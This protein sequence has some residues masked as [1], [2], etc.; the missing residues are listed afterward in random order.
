M[1]LISA[2]IK[3]ILCRS[4]TYLLKALGREIQKISN[5]K[6]AYSMT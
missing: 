2:E 1:E 3:N 4:G 6:M 5:Q